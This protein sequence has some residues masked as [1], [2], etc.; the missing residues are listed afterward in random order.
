MPVRNKPRPPFPEFAKK[1]ASA[2]S[3]RLAASPSRA[4]NGVR[5]DHVCQDR[6]KKCRPDRAKIRLRHIDPSRGPPRGFFPAPAV[7]NFSIC[8]SH[9]INRDKNVRGYRKDTPA[10]S[11]PAQAPRSPILKSSRVGIARRLSFWSKRVRSFT[12]PQQAFSATK[13]RG[14]TDRSKRILAVSE[15]GNRRH[16]HKSGGGGKISSWFAQP[17][18]AVS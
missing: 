12:L 4:G 9:I 18:F 10:A 6:R 13:S 11:S 17:L 2:P 7:K 14:P 8:P 1:S 5:T 3:P 15:A 16:T